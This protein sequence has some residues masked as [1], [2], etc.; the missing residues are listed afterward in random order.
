MNAALVLLSMGTGA[1][2]PD[3]NRKKPH[4]EESLKENKH[5]QTLSHA[6]TRTGARAH[7]RDFTWKRNESV[8]ST[9]TRAFCQILVEVF[10]QI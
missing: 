6:D 7:G 2:S 1:S 8:N 5:R 3:S 9:I 4:E 10:A